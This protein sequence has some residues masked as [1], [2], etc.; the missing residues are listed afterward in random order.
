MGRALGSSIGKVTSSGLYDLV[1]RPHQDSVLFT[2]P[3]SSTSAA[4]QRRAVHS[5]RPIQAG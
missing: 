2:E 3:E 5:G 1:E 4:G